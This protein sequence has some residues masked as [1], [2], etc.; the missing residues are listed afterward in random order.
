MEK[1]RRLKSRYV[2]GIDP[3]GAYLEGKGT[4][5]ICLMD[6]KTLKVIEVSE[7][8]AKRFTDRMEYWDAH[9]MFIRKILKKHPNNVTVSIE[10]YL[11]YQN[12]LE[13]QTNST[14]ETIQLLGVIKHYCWAN[15]VPL[16]IRP[17]SFAKTRCNDRVLEF[18]CGIEP[19]MHGYCC[20]SAATGLLSGHELDAIRHALFYALLENEQDDY[21]ENDQRNVIPTSAV[22]H[23][24][25]KRNTAESDG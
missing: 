5:G 3:S 21:S 2:I 10:D 15:A 17:A 1:Q 23:C 19:V 9:L 22:N 25:R 13:A 16:Y 8:S 6:C 12:K 4:T 20:P 24:V 11:L 14:C 18:K 7:I